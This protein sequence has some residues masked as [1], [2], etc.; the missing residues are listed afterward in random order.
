MKLEHTVDKER[1]KGGWSELSITIQFMINLIT[2]IFIN[3][4]AL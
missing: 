4:R 3:T 2:A 1:G